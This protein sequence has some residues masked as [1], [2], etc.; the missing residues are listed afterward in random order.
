M[1]INARS[2]LA[3]FLEVKLLVSDTNV[4]V[5]C[6]SETWLLP[7]TPDS[8]VHLPGYRVFRCDKGHGGGTCVYVKDT[9]SFKEITCDVARPQGVEDVWLSI[10]CRK[11]PSVIVG[12]IYRHPKAPQETFDYLHEILRN[13]SLRNKGLYVLGDLN[14]D[15]LTSGNKLS[16]IIRANKLHQIIDK[17]TRVT[18]Q[19]ATLLDILIT[20]RQH[21]IIHTDVTPS[22][23][24][25]HDQ[26]TAT[27]NITKP[28]R[29]PV[30]RTAR[31]LGAYSK[32]Y[33]C[34]ALIAA[35]PALRNI[36]LTDD[37]DTQVDI[38]NSVFTSCLNQ[39]A[40]VVTKVVNKPF[41]PWLNDEIRSAMATRNDLQSRLKQDR[42][43]AT[44][45]N[46]INTNE[47]ESNRCYAMR[48]KHFISDSSTT[49]E[50]TPPLH[51][52]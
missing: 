27:I 14:D 12:S 52:K 31:H 18:P 25:D 5:L 41:A 2:L 45:K 51:G 16:A 30:T 33:L 22:T 49:V 10:Q 21:T 38:L 26:I 34:N 42:R 46:N 23:I 43:N 32:E 13:M 4:D 48:N 24:A 20:N 3:N 19:S 7:H 9:L 50:A 36:P 47:T 29:L 11:L 40:P 1:H 39:C 15:W 28:K 44:L 35:E 17:P 8:F 37:V 6:V